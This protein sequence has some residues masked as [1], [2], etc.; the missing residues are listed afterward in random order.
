MPLQGVQS[1]R[2]AI[3]DATDIVVVAFPLPLHSLQRSVPLLH[4]PIRH[5]TDMWWL[6]C[7]LGST[8]PKPRPNVSPDSGS[9]LVAAILDDAKH[10]AVH[11]QPRV[12]SWRF[13]TRYASGRIAAGS[14]RSSSQ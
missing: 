8:L 6:L 1:R 3:A 5:I 4:S 12:N 7:A 11:R 13:C 10:L 2:T 14:W 9:A